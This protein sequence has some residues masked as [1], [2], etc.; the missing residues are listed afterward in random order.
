MVCFKKQLSS[1]SL[2]IHKETRESSCA[3]GSL[4]NTNILFAVLNFG[5]HDWSVWLPNSRKESSDDSM[6]C[7]KKQLRSR[8]LRIHN[9]TRESSCALG[10]LG[11][12]NILH[13]GVVFGSKNREK[14]GFH[15]MFYVARW[16]EPVVR[17]RTF[18]DRCVYPVSMTTF[19]N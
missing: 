1:R 2:R 17:A 12:T 7:F 4:G 11:N 13:F 19:S 15:T 10:S 9:E 5:S 14:L 18:E 6:V 8:S 16:V 3:L